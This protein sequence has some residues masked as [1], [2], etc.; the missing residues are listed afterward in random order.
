M[1]SATVLWSLLHGAI[2]LHLAQRLDVGLPA[3]TFIEQV[4]EHAETMLLSESS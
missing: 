2:S 3:S 1:L 4:V